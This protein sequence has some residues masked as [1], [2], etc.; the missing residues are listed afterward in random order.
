MHLRPKEF[1]LS[2]RDRHSNAVDEPFCL[3]FAPQSPQKGAAAGA[4]GRGTDTAKQAVSLDPVK[5]RGRHAVSGTFRS[6]RG[7]H[8]KEMH[9]HSYTLTLTVP[10]HPHNGSQDGEVSRLAHRQELRT[11]TAE[12]PRAR[13]SARAWQVLNKYFVEGTKSWL[14]Y[15]Q[16][17]C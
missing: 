11:K 2:A 8:I 9:A 15:R 6:R 10:T 4:T 1:F 3:E 12:G 7:G 5:L 16:T 14:K 13:P 17:G